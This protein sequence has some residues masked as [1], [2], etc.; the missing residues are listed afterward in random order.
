MFVLATVAAEL[1]EKLR[2]RPTNWP[3][4]R[5]WAVLLSLDLLT[6]AAGFIAGGVV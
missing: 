1:R 2:K 6:F 5:E 3:T 4:L